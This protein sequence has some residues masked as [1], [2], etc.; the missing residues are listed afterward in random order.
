[1]VGRCH[2]C[3]AESD[4]KPVGDMS[5]LRH[6]LDHAPHA[7]PHLRDTTSALVVKDAR[8]AW[9][10]MKKGNDEMEYDSEKNRRERQ[11]KKKK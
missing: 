3:N 2:T 11:K 4:E 10:T 5:A 1:M 9:G 8:S 6:C 7:P